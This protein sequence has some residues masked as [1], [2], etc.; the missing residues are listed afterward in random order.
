MKNL[1]P[2]VQIDQPAASVATPPAG[3]IAVFSEGGVLKQK[4]SSGVV[5]TYIGNTGLTTPGTAG[6]VMTSDGTNW[7][8]QVMTPPSSF[9]LDGGSPTTSYAGT[10]KIDFGGVT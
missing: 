8:S 4:A 10:M 5:T 6:N 1:V 7:T 3:Y 9:S 2:Q